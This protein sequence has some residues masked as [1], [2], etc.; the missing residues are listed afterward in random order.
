MIA[1]MS[2]LM[3]EETR[4]AQEQHVPHPV[5]TTV[6]MHAQSAL[7]PAFH[8]TTHGPPASASGF[9]AD[10]GLQNTYLLVAGPQD[11]TMT[12]TLPAGLTC[13]SGCVL[14]W[15][16]KVST[17]CIPMVR[18]SGGLLWHARRGQAAH[19]LLSSMHLCRSG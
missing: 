7:L 10:N 16:Y 3:R 18:S 1:R 2:V 8:M 13:N 4:G 15:V 9:R 12:Y 11:I 6:V 5:A 17:A 14:Q 19:G